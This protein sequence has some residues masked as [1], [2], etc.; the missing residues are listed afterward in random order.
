METGTL[1]IGGLSL[2]AVIVPIFFAVAH[3]KKRAA[4][5]REVLNQLAAN[6]GVQ[7]GEYAHDEHVAIGMNLSHRYIFLCDMTS[8]RQ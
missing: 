6:Y 8:K 4:Q 5:L 2:A 7:I 1:V 3:Q